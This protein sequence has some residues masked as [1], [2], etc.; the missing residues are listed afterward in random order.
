MV[1]DWLLATRTEVWEK[2]K[3]T[4]DKDAV[5][6]TELIAFQQDLASLRKLAHNN[7]AALPRVGKSHPLYMAIAGILSKTPKNECICRILKDLLFTWKTDHQLV[8]LIL[9]LY[10]YKELNLHSCKHASSDISFSFHP[11]K[12]QLDVYGVSGVS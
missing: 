5:S 12:L 3:S 1:C 11:L 8:K 4:G 9:G 7:K 10:C 6:Q 2:E